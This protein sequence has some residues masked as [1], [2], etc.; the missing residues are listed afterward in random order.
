MTQDIS[1]RR[2]DGKIRARP[3]GN[4][5]TNDGCCCCNTQGEVPCNE[6]C[7]KRGQTCCTDGNDERCCE[8]D[9][10]CCAANGSVTCCPPGDTCC[11]GSN[12]C[13]PANRVCCNGQC[14]PPNYQCVNGQCVPTPCPEG[15]TPCGENCCTQEQTC[16]SN[17]CC[18][19]VCCN[20]VCCAPGQVCVGGVCCTPDE[21]CG[22]ECCPY[23]FVC[24]GGECCDNPNFLQ[25]YWAFD[26]AADG[27]DN[28]SVQP[29]FPD[30]VGCVKIV[31]GAYDAG[32]NSPS[33]Q[34]TFSTRGGVPLN[35]SYTPGLCPHVFFTLSRNANCE[36]VFPDG[37]K[38]GG[39]LSEYQY[40]V[41]RAS[42]DGGT[43]DVSDE[44]IAD[45]FKGVFRNNPDP[46]CV[47]PDDPPLLD[48]LSPPA[49]YCPP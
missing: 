28:V 10:T 35:P 32:V 41:Y 14:C 7:C 5:A 47:L 39:E 34:A 45:G 15:Q 3:D 40:K 29:G 25:C 1:L 27:A 46:P 33:T 48:W 4:L 12:N 37:T 13:C 42:C 38:G 2:K 16:C 8:A 24:C 20:G 44:A 9:E 18:D 22:T 23:P 31:L 6:L 11:P 19:N 21:V 17:S 30:V 49:L 26:C 36:T 43:V